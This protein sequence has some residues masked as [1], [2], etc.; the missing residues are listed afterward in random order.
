MAKHQTGMRIDRIL[1][2]QFQEICK[3]EKLRP[4][5]AVESLIRLAVQAGSITGVSTDNATSENTV[6][7]FD[8]ALFRSRLARLKTSLELE[9]R[10]WKETGE[11]I[12]NDYK[13]SEYFIER[14]T[15]LGRRAVSLE[16]VK[17]F[18]AVLTDSDKQ[19]EEMQKTYFER[20]INDHKT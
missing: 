12:G 15:E 5:E 17:E 9:E 8:D 2:K 1:F 6:R 11:E 14:L 3:T 4:G 10:Y 18:E 20:E 13:E 19:Y 7:M 16:L